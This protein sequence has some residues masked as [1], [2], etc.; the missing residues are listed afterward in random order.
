MIIIDLLIY[1]C[2]NFFLFLGN[3]KKN[4]S[5]FNNFNDYNLYKYQKVFSFLKANFW[6]EKNILYRSYYSMKKLFINDYN[7]MPE[8]YNYPDDKYLI[9][10][11]FKDYHLN[12]N[13]LW[14]IKPTNLCG[15]RGISFLFS[16]Q[17]IQYKKYVITKYIINIDLIKGKKYDI[18][19]FVLISGLNPLRI[20]LYQ[21]GIVR[22]ASEKFLIT[23]SSIKNNFIHLTNF[24]INKL[25]KNYMSPNNSSDKNEIEWNFSRYIS[26]LEGKNID[27][28]NIKEKVKDII[29]KIIICVHK[30]INEENQR[31]NVY[32]QSFFDLLG[33]DIIITDHYI[34]KLI[35]INYIPDIRIYS[36]L[37]KPIKYNLFIDTLNLIGIIPFSRNTGET[38]YKNFIY[39][40]DIDEK[41]NNALC[42][43]ERPKGNY[44]LIFPTKINISKYNKYF[45]NNSKENLIFWDKILSSQ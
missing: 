42:E 44:E 11:K 25:N 23:K 39:E 36:N 29:I 22:I 18:R 35:E 30:K 31:Q 26:Y 40:S 32:D 15:G 41:I 37:Q 24:N 28:E 21:E 19:F 38:L 13:D 6:F 8:T 20:Y 12:L 7:F 45:I 43:L 16:L 3:I 17:I 34:P 10:N 27:W 2:L 14:L 5:K 9:E 1:R 33:F 4:P